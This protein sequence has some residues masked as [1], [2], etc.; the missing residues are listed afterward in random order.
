MRS[1]ILPV[2]EDIK[3][4]K[5]IVRELVME[6]ILTE[7]FNQDEFDN[8]MELKLKGLAKDRPVLSLTEIKQRGRHIREILN[9]SSRGGYFNQE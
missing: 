2:K 8:R 3:D 5:D 4:R 1:K 7:E 6:T 9:K